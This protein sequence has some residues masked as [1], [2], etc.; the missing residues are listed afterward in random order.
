MEK[1]VTYRHTLSHLRWNITVPAT[2]HFFEKK[3]KD[4]SKS[5]QFEIVH[6]LFDPPA[7]SH[8]ET[9]PLTDVATIQE[10]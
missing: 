3:E 9:A 7:N 4:W 2:N 8:T 5:T 6:W 10:L 1:G